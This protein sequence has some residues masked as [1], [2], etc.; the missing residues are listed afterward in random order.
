MD[1]KNNIIG[2]KVKLLKI[3]EV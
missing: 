1:S 3:K 2:V